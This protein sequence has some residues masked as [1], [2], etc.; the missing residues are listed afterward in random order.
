VIEKAG[1][2][3]ITE[4]ITYLEPDKAFGQKSGNVGY[5]TAADG[6]MVGQLGT[7]SETVRY[8]TI[9]ADENGQPFNGASTYVLT[10][11]AG[12]VHKDGYFSITV[13]GADN[14]LLIAN[15]KKTYDRARY[16]SEQNADGTISTTI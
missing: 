12:I 10:V 14:K 9:L 15:D 3:I 6:L 4:S 5:I 1:L 8:G 11:P 7:P 13:Y 16:S 2:A